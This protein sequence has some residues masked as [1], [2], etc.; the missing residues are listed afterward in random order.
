MNLL[1][2]TGSQGSAWQEGEIHLGE[3][4]LFRPVFTATCTDSDYDAIAIDDISFLA[5]PVQLLCSDREADWNCGVPQCINRRRVCDFRQD[6]FDQSDEA[7]CGDCDFQYSICGWENQERDDD[8]DWTRHAGSTWST[9]TGPS[10]D[11]TW[12]NSS[13]GYLYMEASAPRS[14]GD[15]AIL[16]SPYFHSSGP[17]CQLSLWYH[18]FGASVDKL[19]V[20][21]SHSQERIWASKYDVLWSAQGDHNDT[22]NHGTVYIGAKHAFRIHIVGY[23]GVSYDGDI[24]IDDIEFLNCAGSGLVGDADCDFEFGNCGYDHQEYTEKLDWVVIQA[25]SGGWEA[26]DKDHSSESSKGELHCSVF[27]VSTQFSMPSMRFKGSCSM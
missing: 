25:S 27:G 7:N 10:V 8:F 16:D 21:I 20:Q 13:G 5:C 14:P 1:K 6:C 19:E 15:I 24:A 12:G 18:M 22:W 3:R 26:P 4:G 9:G 2:I 17:D 23:I 11:H